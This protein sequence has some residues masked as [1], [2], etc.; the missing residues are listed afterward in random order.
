MA[1]S[2]NRLAILLVD[3]GKYAEV[4]PLYERALKIRENTLGI[5][6]PDVA[7]ILENMAEFYIDIGKKDDAERMDRP[8]LWSRD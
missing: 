1:T 8:F 4:E 3:Q 5:D 2:L 6:H 7:V